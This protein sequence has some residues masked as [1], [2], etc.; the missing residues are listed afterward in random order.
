MKFVA[1][2]P[3]TYEAGSQAILLLHGF[4]GTTADVRKLGRYLHKKGYT[5]H[6]PLYQGHGVGP[7]ALIQTGPVNWWQDAVEGYRY[8]ESN[9]YDNI[10]VAGVSMGG[11]FALKMAVELPVAA[12]VSMSSPM[13]AKSIED[14]SKRIYNY[15]ENYK[16]VEGKSIEVIEEELHDFRLKPKPFLTDLQQ[17]I[18]EV[19]GKLDSIQVPTYVL[20][21]L[22]DESLYLKSA[23]KIYQK[24]NTH[25]K[26]LKWYEN[27]GHIMTT[28]P[29]REQ[30]FEDIS[31]MIKSL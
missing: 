21:G 26:Q 7:E 2:K 29:E 23:E 9:G 31:Q 18:I 25:N 14:L 22:K 1:P 6:A 27:S 24:V 19:S 11:V 17:F 16:K 28:G 5:V 13:Q 10:I 4:T 3:F 15:A 30:I 8:L 20:Q 12:V